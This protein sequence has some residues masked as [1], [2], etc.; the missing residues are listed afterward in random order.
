MQWYYFCKKPIAL[1][2]LC[3]APRAPVLPGA[4]WHYIAAPHCSGAQYVCSWV[5]PSL[6]G[7]LTLSQTRLLSIEVLCGAVRYI[8]LQAVAMDSVPPAPAALLRCLTLLLPPIE[9]EFLTVDVQLAA[10]C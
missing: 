10:K 2:Q 1:E 8:R 4:P 5:L 6:V 9:V 7:L 3:A